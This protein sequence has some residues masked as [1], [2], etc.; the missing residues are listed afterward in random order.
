MNE[1]ISGSCF[2][3]GSTYERVWDMWF[4]YMLNALTFGIGQ[5]A[6]VCRR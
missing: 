5:H 3:T 6:S 1:I 2:L 4:E